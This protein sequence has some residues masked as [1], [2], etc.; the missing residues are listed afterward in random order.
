MLR[1]TESMGRPSFP[2]SLPECGDFDFQFNQSQNPRPVSATQDGEAVVC[3]EGGTDQPQCP[4][5]PSRL[6]PTQPK[7]R[8]EWSTGHVWIRIQICKILVSIL[9]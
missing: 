8:L 5:G 1:M 4:E 7:I 9:A 2:R 6:I 3:I